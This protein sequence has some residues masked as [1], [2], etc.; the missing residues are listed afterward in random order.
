MINYFPI[1]AKSIRVLFDSPFDGTCLKIE[2]PQI[3]HNVIEKELKGNT[4]EIHIR[5][6]TCD[7][8]VFV[9]YGVN[10]ISIVHI[11]VLA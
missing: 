10:T 6:N 2:I 3:T 5:K 9:S 8:S 1:S 11:E 7:N 4:Y